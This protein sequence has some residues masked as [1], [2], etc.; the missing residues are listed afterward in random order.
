MDVKWRVHNTYCYQFHR[1]LWV[2]V[3]KKDNVCEIV[4]LLDVRNLHV[5][6]DFTIV[7]VSI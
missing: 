1:V 2:R 5:L 3:M 6:Y 4:L 7:A